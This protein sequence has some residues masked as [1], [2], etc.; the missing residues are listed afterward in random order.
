M[1]DAFHTLIEWLSAVFGRLLELPLLALVIGAATTFAV[2][3]VVVWIAAKRPEG[4]WGMQ[5]L[6][7][8]AVLYLVVV[9]ILVLDHRLHDLRL[10]VGELQGRLTLSTVGVPGKAGDGSGAGR[11]SLWGSQLDVQGTEIVA[12][13]AEALPGGEMTVSREAEG[14]L[15][16]GYRRKGRESLQLHLAL[17]DL[18]AR[19]IR[20]EITE[21]EL[22]N[23]KLTSEFA[24]EHDCVVAIN[25]EAGTSMTAKAPLGKWTGNWIVRGKPIKLEDTDERPFLSFDAKNRPRYFPAEMVVATNSPEK[26]NT[27]WGR[28]DLLVNGEIA[29]D[30]EKQRSAD[31]WHPRTA[32]AISENGRWLYLLVVDGRLI[33]FSMGLKMEEA[34]RVLKAMGA[35]NGMSCDQGGSSCMY[36]GSLGRLV[37]SPA[38]RT[39]RP[40]W[41]HFGISI[42]SK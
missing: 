28:F 30:H 14:V 10:Q 21:R 26:H 22:A 16:V 41:T 3:A 15:Y 36:L 37:S 12:K 8:I 7:W 33:G 13:L 35:H 31:A 6:R 32:M 2:G 42:E 40:V 25:G 27:I 11:S 38:D 34:A 9:A 24:A 18:R 29:V 20:I 4:W 1:A 39:E 5:R 17:V 19:G 23:K